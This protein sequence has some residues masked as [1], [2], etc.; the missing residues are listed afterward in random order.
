MRLT[1]EKG[2]FSR[3]ASVILPALIQSIVQCPLPRDRVCCAIPSTPKYNAT[4][5][6]TSGRPPLQ[7]NLCPSVS[8][9]QNTTKGEFRIRI[10]SGDHDIAK[11]NIPEIRAPDLKAPDFDFNKSGHF[12]KNNGSLDFFR[13]SIFRPCSSEMLH[14][15][16]GLLSEPIHPDPH[17]NMSDY[18]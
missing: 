1:Q 12:S 14:V 10:H 7:V 2:R 5:T 6:R 9:V 13:Q 15:E 17:L 18:K 3:L 4:Y 8:F 16:T 11:L